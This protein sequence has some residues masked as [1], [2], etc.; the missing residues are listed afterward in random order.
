[1]IDFLHPW[2]LAG[3]AA[4][5]IPVLLHLLAR[6]EPPTVVFPAVRYLIATTQEHLRRL[7]LQNLLLLLVRT[8]LIATLVLAAAGPTMPRTGLPTHAPSA[9]V[10]IVDNSPSSG[11]VVAGTSRLARLQEAG[12]SVLSRA[13]TADALWLLTADGVPQRGDPTTLRRQ[14]DALPVSPYRLDLGSALD[15]AVEVLA[16][17]RRP[18]EVTLLSDLQASAVSP[19]TV[20]VP[21]VV[22]RPDDKTPRNIGIG[23]LETGAQPWSTDGGRITVRLVG[24]SGGAVPVSARLGGRPARQVLAPVGASAVFPIMTAPTGWWT[25]TADLDPDELRIDDRRLA[26]VRVAPVARVNWDSASR[27]TVAACE[28]L[29][30]NRRIARG[31]EVT[32]DRLVRG[33]SILTPPS[34]P[35]E[36]GALNRAL[37]ARGIGWAFGELLTASATSDSG[38][39]V[40]RFH[41]LRRYQ[42]RPSGRGRMGVLVTV[43]GAPW[44]VRSGNTVLIGSRLD[45]DWT[46]LPVS[47]GFMPFMDALL[48]RL[49]RGE[50][51]LAD[52]TPGD[53][54]QLPDFVTG[55]KQGERDWRVEGGGFFRPHDPGVYYLV[56]GDDTVGAVSANIDPRESLLTRASDTRVKTLWRGARPLALQ[57]VGA[58]A[59]SSAARGDLRGPLLWLALVLGLG[60]MFLASA[61]RRREE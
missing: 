40:G 51:S 29:E 41:V 44:L 37:A 1:M 31:N 28:V 8:A 49:A 43:A 7:K 59:F 32:I 2:A 5:S 35:A 13:T 3:L 18:G 56:A 17:D 16:T 15:L 54:V 9:L 23:M 60:E 52:G 10:L 36:I 57:D 33:S 46:D 11:A 55:V 6:R 21:V 47:A 58:A 61:L 27:Y 25:V 30:T 22:G 26:V 24:D 12:R 4:A 34:D 45:P 48:N 39:L 20:P 38:A 14:L 19:A 50:V 42:L 53:P